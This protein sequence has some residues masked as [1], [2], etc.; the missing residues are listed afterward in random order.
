MSRI[1]NA[2]LEAKHFGSTYFF[3]KASETGFKTVLDD[4]MAAYALHAQRVTASTANMTAATATCGRLADQL[5]DTVR[6]VDATVEANR[7]DLEANIAE[8]SRQAVDRLTVGI[9]RCETTVASLKSNATSVEETVADYVAEAGNRMESFEAAAKESLASASANK[10]AFVEKFGEKTQEAAARLAADAAAIAD[11]IEKN[12]RSDEQVTLHLVWYSCSLVDT[13]STVYTGPKIRYLMSQT[14]I[15]Q[16]SFVLLRVFV[17][18]VGKYRQPSRLPI[19][20]W[21]SH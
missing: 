14:E 15:F 18:I 13:G 17:D 8:Q 11:G 16:C 2:R 5:V 19:P 20:M 10:A 9:R 7:G 4:M 12:I 3:F 21:I 6:S 1:P